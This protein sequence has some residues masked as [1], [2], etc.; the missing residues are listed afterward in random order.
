M[1]PTAP[2]IQETWLVAKQLG[3]ATKT[4]KLENVPGNLCDF[5]CSLNCFL[6]RVLSLFI[7]L[8]QT[9]AKPSWWCLPPTKEA[10]RVMAYFEQKYN[11]FATQAVAQ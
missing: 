6:Y 7:V 1:V 3:A 2:R 9:G 4:E 11:A 5:L 10:A 8:A